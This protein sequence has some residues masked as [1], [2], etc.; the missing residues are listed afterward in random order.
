MAV[1]ARQGPVTSQ[2]DIDLTIHASHWNPFTVLGLHEIPGASNG[3]K[4]W[5]IRAF[6]PEA[7]TAW[8]VDLLRGEPGEVV[9]ME[10]L[11]PDG[12]FQATFADRAEPFMYR[13]KIENFE[14]HQWQVVDP[15]RF[16]PVLTD[17]DLHL[18][19]EGTHLR[20]YERLGAHLRT[21]EGFRGVHFA[22]WA[23]NAERVSVT[24]NFNHW[25]GRR[26][27]MRNRG[28]TGVWE[29][30]IPDLC[31]GEVYKFEIKSRNHG[32]VVQ[33]ADPYGFASELRPKT[34]SVIWDLSKFTWDD[35]EWMTSRAQRQ[36]LDRP[37]SFYEVHLGSW[38]KGDSSTSGFLNYRQL[39]HDL[40]AP[41]GAHEFHSHRALPITEHPFD[42]SWGYQPV[43]YLRRPRGMALRMTS[44]T[45]STTSIATASE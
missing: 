42:G 43:G 5:V 17:F 14:G 26:H 13:L 15:Y 32:Y 25:D 10:R 6:L 31:E 16:G 20:N 21:H 30:F 33:K 22:V 8:V 29:L 3:L 2:T 35:Q 40:A 41:P 38:K 27:P 37:L 11:H 34:A 12:L 36:G 9:S 18:L 44:R 28:A 4:E 19:G 23:P 1:M 45:S 24:G 39:A 7:R